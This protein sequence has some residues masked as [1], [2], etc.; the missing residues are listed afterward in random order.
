MW[1]RTSEKLHFLCFLLLP[2]EYIRLSRG[3]SVEK[4]PNPPVTF[5]RFPFWKVMEAKTRIARQR[6]AHAN[7]S[8]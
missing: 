7:S 3:Y 5:S 4:P 6:A 1:M 2:S 8:F